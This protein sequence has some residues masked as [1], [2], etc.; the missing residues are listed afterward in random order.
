MLLVLHVPNP[1]FVD[2]K[3]TFCDIEIQLFMFCF[4][5]IIFLRENLVS[6]DCLDT[7]VDKAPRYVWYT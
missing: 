3:Y 1:T 7:L 4:Y 5:C 6:L 2:I